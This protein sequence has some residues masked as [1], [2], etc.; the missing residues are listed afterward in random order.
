MAGLGSLFIDLLARTGKFETD[1]GRAARVAERRSRDMQRSFD[2]LGQRIGAALGA[3]ASVQAV[4]SIIR[5]SDQYTQ[6]RGRLALVTDG[7]EELGKVQQELFNI[8]QRTRTEMSGVADLY[9]KLAQSGR[10]LGA[11]QQDLLRFTEG[12][13]NALTVSGSSAQAASGALQQLSQAL[14]GTKI[15]AE[16]FNSINDGAP[17]I[18]RAVARNIDGLDGSIGKLRIAVKS[19]KVTSRDF[20]EAFLKDTD[21]LAAKAQSMP[22]TVGQAFTRMQNNINQAIAG[23]NM[24]PIVDS[25]NQLSDLISDPTFQQGFA[26]FVSGII[27][28]TGK[29]AGLIAETANVARFVGESV[30]ARIQGVAADDIVRLED[31]LAQMQEFRSLGILHPDFLNR[32]RVFGKNGFIEWYSDEDLDNSIADIEQKI[33]AFYERGASRP[34]LLAAGAGSGSGSN[35]PTEPSEEFVKLS[36][37]LKEQIALYGKV[38][39]A[40]EIAYQIQSGALDELSKSE[41]QQLLALARRYDAIVKVEDAKK[42][43]SEE[44]KKAEEEI[45]KMIAAAEEQI[46]TFGKGEAAVVAYRLAHSELSK[47]FPESAAASAEMGKEIDDL[48]AKMEGMDASSIS[49]ARSL[50]DLAEN[51]QKKAA[52]SSENLKQKLIDITLQL[53]I[54]TEAANGA[55]EAVSDF[56]SRNSESLDQGLESFEKDF[57]K[58]F[59]DGLDA[60]TIFQE[61]A[62][63]NTQDIIADTLVSGFDQGLDG[64]VKSFGEMIKKL[65]AQAVAADIAKRLFGAAGGGTGGGWISMAA[66]A[67]GFGGARAIGGPV[68]AGMNYRVNEREPEFFRPRVGGDIIPLSKMPNM[69]GGMVVNQNFSVRAE[70][71]ERVSRSTEQQIAA[72][73]SRGMAM[74]SRRNN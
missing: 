43:S 10:E 44:Q 74:A 21:S 7:T 38:G 58:R 55:A 2:R 62:A 69:G 9:V 33:K 60:L 29:S 49:A 4:Q 13:G 14:S 50:T 64:V 37:K 66:G 25:I 70:S 3:Y 54:M 57:E 47:A 52:D 12:I 24:T 40:A 6:L 31:L 5:I 65:I 18:L 45:R 15:Q 8:A 35:T 22:V 42:K 61:Q 73:A 51:A 63:R 68:L 53:E 36:D 27:Q 19:G 48:I 71:G 11:S 34:P 56:A 16:E 67:L 20:F 32:G 1:I 17:E 30:A 26:A 46:A 72:A 23:V 39:K 41:Q 59:L 28:V